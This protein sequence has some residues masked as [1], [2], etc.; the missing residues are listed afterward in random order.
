MTD[1]GVARSESRPKL[2][3]HDAGMRDSVGGLDAPSPISESASSKTGVIAALLVAAMG[4]GSFIYQSVLASPDGA[5]RVDQTPRGDRTA[6]RILEPAPAQREQETGAGLLRTASDEATQARQ[7]TEQAAADLRQ[8]LQ[9]ERDRADALDR[10]LGDARREIAILTATAVRI[11]EATMAREVAERTAAT[12]Q[13][14]LEEERARTAT[15]TRDLDAARR[16]VEAEAAKARAAG[17]D[18]AKTKAEIERSA[19]ELEQALKH[20]RDKSEKLA[21]ELETARHR[22][23]TQVAELA[24]AHDQQLTELKQALQKAEASTAAYQDSLAQERARRQRLEQ[25][26]AA[27]RDPVPGRE[28]KATEDPPDSQG[29]TPVPVTGTAAAAPLSAAGKQ[30]TPVVLA[31]NRP[32]P[33]TARPP[34][35]E[36]TGNPEAVRLIARASQ[37]LLEG[38]VGA[39]RIVLDRAAELGSAQAAFALAE[40]YDPFSLSA[41]GTLGTQGDA[42][43]ARE[44]YAKALAGG[45][46][47]AKDRLN[48]LRR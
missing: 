29:A 41:W 7:T 32:E 18:A 43:K 38:N 21:R 46:E 20:E 34:A 23:Q 37:L 14:A 35:P 33:T 28:A 39:A 4:V 8:A 9:K 47:E 42:A 44:L 13:Q 6:A 22:L 30:A 40:T 3:G 5:V 12:A 15:L 2:P 27:R 24:G 25:Q 45:V 17:S 26:L 19:A 16:E 31:D 10:D 36:S 11:S 1:N 48:A